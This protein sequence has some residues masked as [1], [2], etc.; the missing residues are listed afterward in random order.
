MRIQTLE[1]KQLKDSQI[2]KLMKQIEHSTLKKTLKRNN[3]FR[4]KK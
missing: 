2:T 4:T 1:Q 3:N